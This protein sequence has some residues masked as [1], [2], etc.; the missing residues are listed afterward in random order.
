MNAGCNGRIS[1][2][3]EGGVLIESMKI[4][5]KLSVYL[6]GVCAAEILHEILVVRH[7]ATQ[8]AYPW[9]Y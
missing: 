4:V 6:V 9:S 2:L 1:V 8:I 5:A 7:G 3:S